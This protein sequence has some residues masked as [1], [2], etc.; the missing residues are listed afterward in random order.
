LLED[1]PGNFTNY[2]LK[3]KIGRDILREANR[4]LQ[5]KT[6]MSR[7]NPDECFSMDVEWYGVDSQGN[8]AV[9]CNAGEGRLP[10]FVCE[11]M[12]RVDALI[13]YFNSI[14]NMTSSVLL[15]PKTERAEQIA[16]DFSD[17]GLYYFDADDGTKLEICT[18][19]EYYTK[20]SYPKKPLKYETLPK[21][22]KKILKH[23][24]M[25]VE[26]FFLADKIYIKHAYE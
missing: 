13:E 10:K 22:I 16:R 24:F 8:I 23:N 4:E 14:E 17:R 6:D 9:F 18:L 2:R 26:D 19:H 7:I 1:N 5:E 20:Q 15:F 12:E 3:F 21:S 11:D 25:E